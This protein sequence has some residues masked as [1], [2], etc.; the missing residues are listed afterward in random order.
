[1]NAEAA[2]LGIA[3]VT[4]IE[5][6]GPGR[7]IQAQAGR[8]ER[9]VEQRRRLALSRLLRQGRPVRAGIRGTNHV[10]VPWGGAFRNRR[11]TGDSH[12]SLCKTAS[13]TGNSFPDNV[14][15]IPGRN[16]RTR[17]D[18][19]SNTRCRSPDNLTNTSRTTSRRS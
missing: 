15:S 2:D 19:P 14:S 1:G 18:S 16:Q 3:Q 5:Q 13:G 8:T 17:A 12:G 10:Q 7:G 4:E 11:Y 9:R 6:F